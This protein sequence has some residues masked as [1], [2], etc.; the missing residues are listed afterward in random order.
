MDTRG[1]R[2]FITESRKKVIHLKKR[3]KLLEQKR[4]AILQKN[5]YP[6]G[7]S[8]SYDIVTLD[9]GWGTEVGSIEGNTDWLDFTGMLSAL[10]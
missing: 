9:D 3:I 10:K 8:L 6:P 7:L 2:K 4:D 5:S 1:L